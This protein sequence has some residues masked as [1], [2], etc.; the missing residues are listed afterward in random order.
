MRWLLALTVVTGLPPQAASLPGF[1]DAPKLVA[2]CSAKGPDADAAKAVCLG[3][4]LGA[5]DQLLMR[6]GRRGRPAVCPPGDLTASA[7]LSAVMRHERYASSAKGVGAADFV[8]VALEQAWPC[9]VE[10]SGPVSGGAP[11]P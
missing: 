11:D 1:F 10:A 8:R 3:Y 9:P 6:Q 5:A 4:V 7:T 2:L